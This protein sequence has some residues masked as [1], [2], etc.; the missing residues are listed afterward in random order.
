MKKSGL[1]MG[2]RKTHL[3]FTLCGKTVIDFWTDT[4]RDG[5]LCFGPTI[6]N[7]DVHLTVLQS[8]GKLRHHIKHR[9]IK[10][11]PDESPVSGQ[12]STKQVTANIGKMML[13]RLATYHG[14]KTCWVFTPTRWK[15]IQSQLPKMDLRGDLYV[16]LEFVLA[17]LDMDFSKKKLWKKVHIRSLLTSEPHFGYL[18]SKRGL[19]M[20]TPIS[21]NQMLAWPLSKADEVQKY[22]SKVIGIDNFFEYLESTE[23]GKKLSSEI[24]SRL[25]QLSTS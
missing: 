18:Q 2:S 12:I 22:F 13:K 6:P 7:S 19:R 5:G 14:N 21:K 24:K 25:M 17:Q 15:R 8:K 16:P 23:E 3:Y 1:N 10:E 11:P 4:T 20:V 9:G